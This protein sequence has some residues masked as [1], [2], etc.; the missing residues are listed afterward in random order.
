MTFSISAGLVLFFV[1][2][3]TAMLFLRERSGYEEGT[4]RPEN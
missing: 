3:V 4:T 1:L 2:S